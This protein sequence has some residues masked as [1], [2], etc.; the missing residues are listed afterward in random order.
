LCWL[1]IQRHH[2]RLRQLHQM[3]QQHLQNLDLLFHYHQRQSLIRHHHLIH[4][5]HLLN[6][7]LCQTDRRLC[8]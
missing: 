3:I 7:R 5:L 4:Q 6:Y 1:L 2:H 8:L